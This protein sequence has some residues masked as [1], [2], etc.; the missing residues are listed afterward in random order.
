[1]ARRSSEHGKDIN[2][3]CKRLTKLQWILPALYPLSDIVHEIVDLPADGAYSGV[4]DVYLI[5]QDI[6]F[7]QFLLR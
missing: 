2:N 7:G 3:G 1:M 4:H 5:L 6:G